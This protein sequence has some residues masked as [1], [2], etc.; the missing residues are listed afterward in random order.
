MFIPPCSVNKASDD[1][2]DGQGLQTPVVHTFC[3]D[4]CQYNMDT[5]M[6][7]LLQYLPPEHTIDCSSLPNTENCIPALVS[8]TSNDGWVEHSAITTSPVDRGIIFLGDSHDLFKFALIVFLLL[9]L[10]L[11]KGTS[12]VKYRNSSQSSKSLKEWCCSWS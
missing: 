9:L 12:R 11:L 6:E 10:F 3:P 5:C 8:I 4:S 1:G 2:Q 7:D